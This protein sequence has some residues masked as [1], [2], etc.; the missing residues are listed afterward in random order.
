MIRASRQILMSLIMLLGHDPCEGFHCLIS[1]QS[2][3]FVI[4]IGTPTCSVTVT[5]EPVG[6]TFQV[7]FE[8]H[9]DPLV[10]RH[11]KLATALARTKSLQAR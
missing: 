8:D 2:A 6:A 5:E 7:S 3:R 4:A 11:R 10:R 1:G 9:S